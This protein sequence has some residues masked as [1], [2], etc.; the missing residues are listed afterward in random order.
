MT[1]VYVTHN[2]AEAVR[3]GQNVVML[4]RRPGRIRET[5]RIERKLSERG[6]GDPGLTEVEQHLWRSM[7]DDAAQADRE[8]DLV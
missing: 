2:L 7:R 6:R 3:L 8:L 5:L 1:C 4:S